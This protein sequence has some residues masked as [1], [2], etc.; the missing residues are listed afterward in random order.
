MISCLEIL[1][2]LT[3]RESGSMLPLSCSAFRF[4]E[5]ID[6]KEEAKECQILLVGHSEN[7]LMEADSEPVA[8]S[9]LL[10]FG[11]DLDYFVTKIE[12]KGT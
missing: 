2:H 11:F 7:A 8:D 3:Y 12:K 6:V 1:F 4:G 9:L 5:E 10:V